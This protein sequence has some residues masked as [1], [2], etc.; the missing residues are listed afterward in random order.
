[1]F[2]AG[3]RAFGLCTGG[4]LIP[5]EEKTSLLR[6]LAKVQR[7]ELVNCHVPERGDTCFGRYQILCPVVAEGWGDRVGTQVLY[8]TLQAWAFCVYDGL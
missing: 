6:L 4:C 8:C 7:K 2:I 1:M 5:Q 3:N